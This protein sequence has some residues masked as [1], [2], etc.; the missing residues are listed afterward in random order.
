MSSMSPHR[1]AKTAKQAS[2]LIT[3]AWLETGDAKCQEDQA[4]ALHLQMIPKQIF[5]INITFTCFSVL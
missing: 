3:L 2:L 5:N 4:S 1:T